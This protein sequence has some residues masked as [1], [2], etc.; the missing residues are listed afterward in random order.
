VAANGT[1]A[2]SLATAQ[3]NN[4]VLTVTQAD[5]SG[6]VSTGATATA[7]DLTPPA[8]ASTLVVSG[9]GLSLSGTGEAGATVTIKSASGVVL[10]TGIVG[11]TGVFSVTLS[12]A[13]INGE[14]L[15]VSLTD[16]RG[17]VSV[18]A[19]VTAPDIDANAPVTASDNLAIAT[20]N[21]APAVTVQNYSDSF[22]S[23]LL[24]AT[25]TYAFTVNAGTSVDPT[26]FLTSPSLVGVL[27]SLTYT[28]QVKN[29]SGAWVTLGTGGSGGLLDVIGLAGVGVR[30]NLP[31]LLSGDYRLVVSN[32]GV[33]I[34]TTVTT[35]LELDITSLTQFNGTAGAATTGN[36]ITDAGT[37]GQADQTGPDNGA[38]LLIMKGGSY[39]AAGSGTTVQGLYGTLTIDST[40]HYTY[41]SNGSVSSVGKVDVFSYE[42]LHANGLSATA[43]LYVRIDSPQATEIW[44]DSNLSSP[45]VLVD[46]TDDIAHSAITLTNQVTTTNSS[47]GSFSVLLGGGSGTY[48]TSVAANT[49]SS[50]TVVVN[51]SNLLSLLGSM[52]VGLYK[53][54]TT[55]GQYVLVKSYGGGSLL[56]LGSGN[57]GINFD[58]QTAGTYQVKV[59]VGGLGVLS[60]VNTSLINIATS[61]NQF[62][63][64]SYTPVAGNLLTDT[65]GGG[66]DMLGSPYTVLS[67]LLAGTY[68]TPGYNGITLA[69]T[70]GSLLVHADGSYT[71]TLNSGLTSA[72][73]GHADVFT[74]QL[75]HPNGT[76]DTATLTIDLDQ[77]GAVAS[78]SSF[79]ALSAVAT[80]TDDHSALTAVAAASTAETIQGTSGNDTLDGTHGGAVTLNGGAGNDTLIIADQHFASVDGGTGTDTL[81]WAGGDAAINLGDLQSRIHNIEILDLNH[82]SSVSLTL[83]LA[84]VLAIT[85]SDNNT[86][87]IKG[88]SNDSV[89]MT[90]AWT[91]E[92]THQLDGI[93][94]TQ[95]T[96]QADPS[97][98][99]WV[100]NG[101]HVV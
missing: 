70:Y 17:N 61:T 47:L 1:F 13:Q 5:P 19:N 37:N 74:Y 30:V 23:L 34:L 57:Y 38:V 95:Y 16:T 50:L 24:G 65:A 3:I 90:D 98:H 43:N 51:A 42:L 11:G 81:L 80:T 88:D 63:V 67:V 53:L 62:V 8:A 45:A 44:S 15:V 25:K 83:N 72:V 41:T 94:Y 78:T 97:H 2:V 48:T 87:V 86:L 31:D 12:T 20:V 55:T 9:D 35:T 26:L 14:R 64:G 7:P 33:N 73:V 49:T 92:G 39:V 96:P 85:S 68:V 75:T 4:E 22:T 84:D 56:S 82:T 28:L 36:V 99:L 89:H 46:A 54:N 27:S 100:Q 77:A 18:G 58:G 79:S 52:T 10:G 93:D 21:I 32:T 59:A 40:G 76:T 91:A 69:G 101:V 6:N 71:Y 66:V 29:A 60:T